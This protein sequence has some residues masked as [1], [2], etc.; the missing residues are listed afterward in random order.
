[1]ELWRFIEILESR[2]H[3]QLDQNL[4]EDK[5]PLLATSSQLILQ[6][7]VDYYTILWFDN[8]MKMHFG[9][10]YGRR[11]MRNWLERVII[12][13]TYDKTENLPVG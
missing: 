6:P 11:E 1:M 4:L 7:V 10:V 8:G 2:L 12:T 3:V 5:P 13:F 9:E